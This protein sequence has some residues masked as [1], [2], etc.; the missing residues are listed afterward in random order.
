MFY[1]NKEKFENFVVVF[2]EI[3]KG[4]TFIIRNSELFVLFQQSFW[5]SYRLEVMNHIHIYY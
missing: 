2:S 1:N 3:K 4:K 5:I